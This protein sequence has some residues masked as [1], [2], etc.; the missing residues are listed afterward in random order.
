MPSGG[1]S[2]E[3]RGEKTVVVVAEENMWGTARWPTAAAATEP[4][5][6]SEFNATLLDDNTSRRWIKVSWK[7]KGVRCNET[8]L[9]Y[10]LWSALPGKTPGLWA[11]LVARQTTQ[12]D[13]EHKEVFFT[14]RRERVSPLGDPAAAA[15]T[16][17]EVLQGV[18]FLVFSVWFVGV[19]TSSGEGENCGRKGISKVSGIFFGPRANLGE[20]G[21]RAGL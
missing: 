7:T 3:P 12:R 14:E 8:S 2:Y 11:A 17:K 16:P 4:A 1:S 5:E 13:A 10:Y 20:D 18:R 6:T 21:F 15:R 9:C 19:R